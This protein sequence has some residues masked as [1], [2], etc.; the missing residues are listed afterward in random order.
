M[1]K[2]VRRRYTDEDRASLVAMLISEGYHLDPAL[3]KKGAL[4][5][6]AKYAGV[7]DST[8]H[9]WFKEKQNPAPPE[10]VNEKTRVLSDTMEN[11]VW[12]MLGQLQET[13]VIAEMS[14]R[15]MATSI[16]ILTDK[17]RLLRGQ[18]T[19]RV[20]LVSEL[21]DDDLERIAS[22]GSDGTTETP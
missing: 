9:R 2:A 1:A 12:A 14:G 19:E 21:S 10:L 4:A 11:I 13:T 8:L 15:D 16:G 3:A 17:M 22:G 5:R 20:S 6:V 18:S 7:P